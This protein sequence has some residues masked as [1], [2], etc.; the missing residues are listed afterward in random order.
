MLNV[1]LVLR[2]NVESVREALINTGA[3]MGL[4]P[5]SSKK[6]IDDAIWSAAIYQHS[7]DWVSVY[8]SSKDKNKTASS[9]AHELE[10]FVLTIS[11]DPEWSWSFSA[12]KGNSLIA[13]YEWK[14]PRSERESQE[15]VAKLER[16]KLIALGLMNA[17]KLKDTK[18]KLN[19]LQSYD[20]RLEIHYRSKI[21]EGRL[22]SPEPEFSPELPKRLHKQTGMST[23]AKIRKILGT[24]HLDVYAAV[25][26]F[27]LA[28][29][30]PNWIDDCAKHEFDYDPDDKHQLFMTEKC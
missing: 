7:P 21:S 26:E 1:T 2:S 6:E 3:R 22:D 19:R 30:L 4:L 25:A 28:L 11:V 27:G 16:E 18:R 10:A 12:F 24:P 23:A 14:L 29:N 5:V 20:P 8:D 15:K 9:L 13:Q 17:D